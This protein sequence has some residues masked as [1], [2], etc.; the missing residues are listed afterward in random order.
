MRYC[1]PAHFLS[2]QSLDLGIE[3][4][5]PSTWRIE[6]SGDSVIFRSPL[7]NM[8]DYTQE[9]VRLD[10]IPALNDTIDDI[11]RVGD[12]PISNN[13]TIII[14]PFNTTL[15]DSRAQLMVYSYID[16][17]YGKIVGMR[18]AIYKS[19]KFYLI[20]YFAEATKFR[21]YLVTATKIIDSLKIVPPLY[22]ESFDMGLRIKYPS[23]WNYVELNETFD[24]PQSIMFRPIEGILSR[25][26]PS[27]NIFLDN[28]NVDTSLDEA[29]NQTIKDRTR[30]DGFHLISSST[31][32]NL[33]DDNLPSQML[34][35]S[36]QY[37]DYVVINATEIITIKNGK[38]YHILYQ[39]EKEEYLKYP[40]VNQIIDSLELVNILR[41]EKLF[42]DNSGVMLQYPNTYPWKIKEMQVETGGKISNRTIELMN[43]KATGTNLTLSVF[44]YHKSLDNLKNETFNHYKNKLHLDILS[45][46]TTLVHT[47]RD[48]NTTAYYVIFTYYDPTLKLNIKGTYI[49][50]KYKDNAYIISFTSPLFY[51][52][53]YLPSVNQMIDSFKIIEPLPV[54]VEKE[55]PY[56]QT[57][58]GYKFRHPL[59]W[60]IS[61]DGSIVS[62]Q[63]ANS[64]AIL[65]I[66]AI[67]YQN[68]EFYEYIENDMRFII[69]SANGNIFDISVVNVTTSGQPQYQVEYRN[70]DKKSL[71]NYRLQERDTIY[72]ISYEADTNEYYNYIPIVR[73]IIESFGIV[74]DAKP[75]TLTGFSVGKGPTGIAVNPKTN[76][77]YVANGYSNTVSVLNGIITN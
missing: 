26:P 9:F 21:D 65:Q 59:N 39:A 66:S 55:F 74:P 8:D 61:D 70:G 53:L 24:S 33:I 57:N 2:Y 7:E 12:D 29:V 1:C 48:K 69:D 75:R 35:F 19:D 73:Q 67:P 38:E 68:I 5:Y 47:S 32:P 76:I 60:N 28:K 36:F 3:A 10:V 52:N 11:I 50:S 71:I 23:D 63:K 51:Y 20:R 46:N 34:N 77:L 14:P 16:D 4:E 30:L 6:S 72:T 64:S 56:Y 40:I 27:I 22:Y 43:S 13:L 58:Y 18:G 25:Y 49:Y 45:E 31:I 17:T 37:T 44:P 41:Y 15:A 42:D 62:L 54:P